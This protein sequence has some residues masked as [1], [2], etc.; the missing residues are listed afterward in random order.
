M[1]GSL[2]VEFVGSFPDPLQPLDPAL[3][4][5]ALVGRSNVGKSTLL[6]ALL[7]RRRLARVSAEPGKTTLLNVFRLPSCYFLDLPGYGYARRGKT[8]RAGFRS[9]LEGVVR[10]RASIS[11]II[12]LLDSRHPPSKDDLDIQDL[13]SASGRAVLTVLTKA[14]KLT[15]REQA[16]ALRARSRELGM[17]E[18]ELLLTSATTGLGIEDLRETILSAA[19]IPD[20]PVDR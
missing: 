19:P 6:N 11:G 9:L 17:S 16:A 2:P 12:W 18:A 14:D 15:R 5:F 8:E 4:E 10:H 7:G 3:A 20:S 1:T 13:L